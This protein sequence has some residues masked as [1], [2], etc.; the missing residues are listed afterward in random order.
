MKH[1]KSMT[2]FG[3]F[4]FTYTPPE[5][6]HY[7]QVEPTI[8]MSISS[9][10]DLQEMTELFTT[11]LSS[12]G[13]FLEEEP[14]KKEDTK[15]STEDWNSFWED[16]GTSLVGN[17]WN[18]VTEWNTT[19]NSSTGDKIVYIGSRL[20]GGSGEDRLSFDPC[21]GSNLMTFS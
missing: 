7:D 4:T 14:L 20:M 3:K 2:D 6:N 18:T 21:F 17:P 13:Y 11:F 9:E 5:T 8:T 10:A 19:A 15:S 1:A 16:D 12:N